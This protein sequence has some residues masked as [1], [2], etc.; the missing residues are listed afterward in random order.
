MYSIIATNQFKKD[1]KN[2]ESGAMTLACWN[3][4]LTYSKKQVRYP[5]CTNPTNYR[6]ITKTAGNAL[7]NRIGF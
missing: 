3:R 1:V 5:N 4:L 2:A 6:A 7:S